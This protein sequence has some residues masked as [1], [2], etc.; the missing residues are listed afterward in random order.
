VTRD[1]AAAEP[2]VT[3]FPVILSAPSGGG[4]TTVRQE[5]QALRSDVGYS[6]SATTRPPRPGEVEGK[7]YFFLSRADFE[8]RRA[9]GELSEW[10]E[11]HGKLYGTP[12]REVRRVLEGGKHVILDI[13]V[14]GARQFV[15][16]F[17]HSVLIFLLPPSASVLLARLLGRKTE[18]AT[19]L[20]RRLEAAREELMSLELYPY[21]VVNED[22]RHTV[23][24]VSSII[25]AEGERRTRR[26]T[27]TADVAAMVADLN[28]EIL[29]LGAA[30]GSR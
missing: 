16:A 15:R 29:A 30:E 9:R 18:G 5:L 11:V 19:E 21:V 8:A 17:P 12:E 25:D 28:R 4:K 22:L 1:A 23:R 14:Q 20:R 7:D 27:H 26:P 6:V 2:H 24:L 3:P 13:D 10:A